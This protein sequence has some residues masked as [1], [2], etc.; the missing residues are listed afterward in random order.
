[1]EI[2][3]Q[4][5]GFKCGLEIHQQLEGKKLFCN[6]LTLNS[7]AEADV[8][9]ERRLRAVA[10]E[11]GKIDIAAKHEMEKGRKIIYEADS[12]DTCL[13][14]CDEEPPHELNIEALETTLKAA[15][16]FNAK[17]VDEIQVMRKTVVDGSNVSGFQRTALGA[18]DGFIE[19]SQGKV[20]IPTICLEEEAAQKLE[21]G[22]NFVRYRLDRLGIP[23]IEIATNAGIKSPEHAKEVAAY[24]GMVLRSVGVKRGLGTI[25]QDVNV[26]IKDG[27]RTEIKGFQDLRSI[28]KVIEYEI[29]RQLNAINQNKKLNEEVRKAEPDFT[30]SFLRPMPGADRLYPETDVVHVKVEKNYVE[31]LK[32]Q[33]PKLL[34]HKEDELEKKYKIT[35]ELAKELIHND[36]FEALIKKFSKIEPMT[37]AHTLVNIP[38]EIKTRFKEDISK[39][40][41]ED[42][43]EVLDYLSKEMIAKEAII[44]LLIKK[45]KNEKIKLE[46]FAGVS[47]QIL[48]KE[49]KELLDKK[50]GLNIGA[51][52]GIL[53]GKYRGKVDGKKIMEILKNLLK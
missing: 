33:L 47:E 10:G 42:F 15:L 29:N 25:R 50:K 43:E 35:K 2:D 19:T 11:T 39:L 32:K 4:K 13:V 22:N 1:M 37:I 34:A 49:I 46:E 6:C 27:A 44:D 3:Y 24:I 40:K 51:Y 14:E 53:M 18:Q 41:N 45:I 38:K 7:D 30:T 17:V 23:L 21:D 16:L 8:K 26:S 20:V 36:I 5:L 52:M 12:A 31:N 48:E 28:P 9:F